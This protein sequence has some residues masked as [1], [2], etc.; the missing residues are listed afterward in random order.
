MLNVVMGIVLGV[1]GQLLMGG[2]SLLSF[3]QTFCM[4]MGIGYLIG[5]YVP[6]MR[7]G[8]AFAGF[9]RAPEGILHY[10][11]STLAISVTM[12]CLITAVSVFIQAGAAAPMVFC[13]MILPFLGV[14]ILAIECTLGLIQRIVI[15]WYR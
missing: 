3:F 8:S 1:T 12:I 15:G 4:T 13:Q 9:C 14:G 7:I 5:S 6:V 11:V 10:L 2:F